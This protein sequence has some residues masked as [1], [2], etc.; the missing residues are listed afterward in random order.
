M[1][2]TSSAHRPANWRDRARRCCRHAHSTTRQ[3]AGTVPAPSAA[4]PRRGRAR[5]AAW[6]DEPYRRRIAPPPPNRPPSATPPP[7]SRG[8]GRSAWGRPTRRDPA[9]TRR[10][11]PGASAAA[12]EHACRD[13]SR[14]AQRREAR[15]VFLFGGEVLPPRLPEDSSM[16]VRT[17]PE[18]V[19]AESEQASQTIH[20]RSAPLAGF[21]G[22]RRVPPPVNEPVKSYAPGSPERA[23]V[24]ARLK[25]MA[26]ER[27]EIPI[28]I[29]GQEIRTGETAQSVMPHNHRHVLADYH[30][31][32]ASHVQKAI[33][34]ARK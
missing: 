34:A 23:E 24:K 31:A 17:A 25:Q 16:A 2:P 5:S 29:G 11:R 8:V 27:V 26:N 21:S 14:S 30:K 12:R 28:I 7:R 4:S 32:S 9:R 20:P 15:Y 18:R 13:N 10:A 33:E 19:A 6:R 22:T 3:T 1:P